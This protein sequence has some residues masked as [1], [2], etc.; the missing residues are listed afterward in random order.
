MAD[1]ALAQAF[2]PWLRDRER[3]EPWP[4]AGSRR[5][6]RPGIGCADPGRAGVQQEPRASSGG[7]GRRPVDGAVPN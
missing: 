3:R 4:S 6:C 2:P 1:G 5:V 7:Y